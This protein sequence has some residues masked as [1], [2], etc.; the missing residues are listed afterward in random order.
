MTRLQRSILGAFPRHLWRSIIR[1]SR[2]WRVRC[3]TCGLSRTYWE[4]GG[5][6]WKA[7]S[8]GKWMLVRCPR[9]GR[10]RCSTIE[11]IVD[12]RNVAA[13]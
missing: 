5:I 7:A 9:C 1:E 11:R 4:M 8:K 13:G 3:L 12:D 10:L 2:Q 6:R